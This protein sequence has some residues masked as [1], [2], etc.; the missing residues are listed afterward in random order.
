MRLERSNDLKGLRED[1]NNS[2]G[3]AEE[4]IIGPSRDA[5]DIAW[6]QRH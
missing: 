3:A 4:D 2:I 1:A 6:L 5:S